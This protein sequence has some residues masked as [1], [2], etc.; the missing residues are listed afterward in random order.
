MEPRML[1]KINAINSAT[2]TMRAAESTIVDTRQEIIEEVATILS[3]AGIGTYEI[4]Q[5]QST[6]HIQQENYNA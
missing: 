3:R 1:D 4:E 2:E 5:Y 6:H